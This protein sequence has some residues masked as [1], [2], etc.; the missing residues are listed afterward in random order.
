MKNL[1]FDFD[2]LLISSRKGVATRSKNKEY[3]QRPGVGIATLD[4]IH[5]CGSENGNIDTAARTSD[6]YCHHRD[7]AGR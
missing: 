3:F 6:A 1:Y 7:S 5:G 4:T 2:V